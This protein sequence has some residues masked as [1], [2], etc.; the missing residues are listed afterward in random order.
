MRLSISVSL[1]F[2]PQLLLAADWPHWHGPDR[3]GKTSES[4]HYDDGAWPPK[5]HVWEANTGTGCSSVV[6]A[7]GELFAIGWSGGRDT[8]SCLDALTGE[9]RWTQSYASADYGRFAIGDKGYYRG[10][11]ST[12]EFDP[13]TGLLYTLSL[14]GDLR[15]WDTRQGGKPGWSLNLYDEFD[16]PQRPQVTDRGGS[17]RDYGY[18]QSPSVRGQQ[19]LL[20]VGSP[21]HGNLIAF[22]KKTGAVVWKSQNRDPAGHSGGL[23]FM[24]VEGVPCAVAIT[25]LNV[26][27]TRL[28]SGHEGEQLA[29]Y[30]WATDF[31]NNIPSPAVS[32]N[33]V[34][35][36]SQYNH[37]AIAKIEIT[38]S[39]GAKKVWEQRAAAGVC[40]P[41]VHAGRV[42]FVDKGVH[43]LDA[44]TG[45]KIWTGGKF[46]RAASILLTSDERLVV[47]A[48]EGDLA[49]VETAGRAPKYTE[50][51]LKRGVLH[52][53]A[54]PHV[55]L[56]N[57][58]LYCKDRTGQIKAF[59]L[60]SELREM[61]PDKPAIP[62]AGERTIDLAGWPGADDS[63]VLAWK[64]G[65]GKRRVDGAITRAGQR[66]A[67]AADG[68]AEFGSSGEISLSGGAVRLENAEKFVTEACKSTNELTLELMLQTGDLG[69][70]GP[71]RIFSFSED[72]YRRNFTIGQERSELRFRLRTP[73]T[74]ENGMNPESRIGQLRAGEI[75]HLLVT[76][77]DGQLRAFLNG[78]LVADEPVGGD[79][80]NWDPAQQLLIGNERGGGRAWIGQVHGLAIHNRFLEP[81][82]ALARYE[83][84]SKKQ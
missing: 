10:P 46:D 30:P 64:Q 25:A 20:E 62:A 26:V 65:Y 84:A 71:A 37:E 14:D 32:R 66:V 3:D 69:Q 9:T 75:L 49:L 35:I 74:G 5:F 6:V 79:L 60:S 73:R 76:Y 82:E 55:V 33:H 18:P 63:I 19:L 17:H 28:D 2:A 22:D 53:P 11:S 1:L 44:E 58:M 40:T 47:W 59:G 8:V 61:Q 68:A 21:K 72:P 12:P 77:R 39:G 27:V 42:Y 36:T 13:E 83:L 50:L 43:C 48:N 16:V 34:F 51:A 38:R 56:A 31:I 24:E 57:G 54:W 78:V 70:D 81:R 80:S 29:S 67:V 15:T 45:E 4:S 7:G 41:V 23:A 52:A